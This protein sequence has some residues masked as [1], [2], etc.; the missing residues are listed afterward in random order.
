MGFSGD[1]EKIR[2]HL[3]VESWVV[4]GG[5]WGSTLSLAYSQTHPSVCKAFNFKRNI[6]TKKKRDSLVLSRRSK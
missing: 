6:L 2:K 1:I 3:C 4:F 5:S